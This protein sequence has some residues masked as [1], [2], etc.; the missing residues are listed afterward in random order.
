VCGLCDFRFSVR[1][2][3]VV[4]RVEV[5]QTLVIKG[6]L[7]AKG[8]PTVRQEAEVRLDEEVQD[9]KIG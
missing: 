6:D 1:F 3:L 7:A 2:D 4:L 5:I 8:D 9:E